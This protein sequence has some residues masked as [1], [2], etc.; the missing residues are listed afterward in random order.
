ML[1]LNVTRT[2]TILSGPPAAPTQLKVDLVTAVS[3]TLSWQSGKDGGHPQIF[4]VLLSPVGTGVYSE[5]QSGN[6]ISDPGC[7][8][9][10]THTVTKLGPGTHYQFQ[11]KATNKRGN[12]LSVKIDAMTWG[13]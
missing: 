7:G 2:C 8:Q 1:A 12:K 11:V 5:S 4:S 10:I 9:V 13:K 3:V 6:A